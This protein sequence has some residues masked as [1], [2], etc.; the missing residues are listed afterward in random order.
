MAT[1]EH[2]P[3]AEPSA[4]ELIVNMEDD[5]RSTDRFIRAAILALGGDRMNITL[6]GRDCEAIR[7]ILH[8]AVAHHD[9]TIQDWERLFHHPDRKP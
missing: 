7:C 8:E 3:E 9:V 4:N 5:L 1:D 2:T 6:S